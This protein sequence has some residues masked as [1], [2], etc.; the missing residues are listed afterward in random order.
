[1][2]STKLALL[3]IAVAASVGACSSETPQP[4][5]TTPAGGTATSTTDR[6][7]V[8]NCGKAAEDIKKHLANNAVRT[9]ELVGQCTTVLINATLTDANGTQAKA[10]CDKAG[11]VAY[12]GDVNSIRV[13][14]TTG[15]ELANAVKGATCVANG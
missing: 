11:A 8:P 10:I 4:A 3:L 5:R 14:G 2:R 1:M 12:T 7:E 15:K 9:V 13:V 6:P